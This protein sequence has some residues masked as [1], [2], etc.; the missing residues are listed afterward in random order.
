VTSE[1]ELI[2]D[3]WLKNLHPDQTPQSVDVLSQM[4]WRFL[5]ANDDQYFITSDNPLFFFSWMGIGKEKSEVTFPISKKIALWATWRVDM[6]EGFFS[7]T[8]Q[9]VKEIN[10]GTAS[11]LSQ[12][13]YS[14]FAD[15]WIQTLANKGKHR[16]TRL[17]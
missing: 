10:R 2:Y 13:L 15:T 14:P 7:T 1:N 12:Y 8:S 3:I 6:T 11:I 16:V 9:A 5:I 4:T 17:I